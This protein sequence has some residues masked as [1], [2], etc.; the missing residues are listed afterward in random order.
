VRISHDIRARQARN[1]SKRPRN[2]TK[3]ILRFRICRKSFCAIVTTFAHALAAAHR[4]SFMTRSQI[5]FDGG[6]R[7][8]CSIDDSLDGE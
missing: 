6:E 8:V 2:R 5:G 3:N 1:T 4:R 7:E